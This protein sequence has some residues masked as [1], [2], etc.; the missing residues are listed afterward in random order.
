ML[1]RAG[2]TDATVLNLAEEVVMACSIC[3]KHVRLPNRPQVKSGAGSA[4]FN[5]CV[6]ADLFHYKQAWIMLMVDECTRYEAAIMVKRREHQELLGRM[7]EH[8]FALFGPPREI[9]LD[10]ESSGQR[11]VQYY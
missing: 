2:I 3:R 6:Q 4:A 9:V 1:A 5:D 10:Q 11:G 8:W 7:M